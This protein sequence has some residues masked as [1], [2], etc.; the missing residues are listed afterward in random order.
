M[1]SVLMKNRK[2]IGDSQRGEE[3]GLEKEDLG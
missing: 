3:A 2:H 1:T